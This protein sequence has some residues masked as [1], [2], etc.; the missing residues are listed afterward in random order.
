MRAIQLKR[1][2]LTL[3]S[4]ILLVTTAVGQTEDPVADSRST[5]QAG[6]VRFT[7]L[8]SQLLRLEWCEDGK[9]ED[10]ASLVFINR[11]LPVPPFNKESAG[12]WLTLK[13]E[14]LQLRYKENSGR[15]NPDNLSIELTL[16]GKTMSWRPGM[17][18]AGNLGG[19]IR[20]LDG[21]KGDTKLES[22]LVSRDGWVLIDDS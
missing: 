10:S 9:F 7:V 20:T 13:T 12:G 2:A 17:K 1:A 18:D 6:N 3:A 4:I 16:N 8:T 21:V 22:G 5:V 14:R 19:T 11:K 15:F